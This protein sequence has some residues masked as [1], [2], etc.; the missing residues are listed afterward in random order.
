MV[1][2]FIR[3][4]MHGNDTFIGIVCII[5]VMGFLNKIRNLGSKF[6]VFNIY[7]QCHC[8]LQVTSP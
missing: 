4:M 5:E 2:I 7:R 1:N 6:A 8:H 3:N